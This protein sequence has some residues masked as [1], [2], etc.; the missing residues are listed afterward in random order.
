M[1]ED[2]PWLDDHQ[3]RVWRL[4]LDVTNGLPVLLNRQLARD[5]D[6]SLQDF[7]VL[8]CLSETEGHA[9]RVVALA[10]AMHWERSRLSHQLTRMEKRGQVLR[11][12]CCTDGRGQLV[13][14]SDKGWDAV[15]AAAPGHADLVRR[16]VFGGLDMDHLDELEQIL[17]HIRDSLVEEREAL[18]S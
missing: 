15:V 11:E 5:T 6:L 17:N 10:D 7:E 1:T 2:T 8:V 16:V 18:E 13:R 12:S 3:Q 14:L 9:M 4:W